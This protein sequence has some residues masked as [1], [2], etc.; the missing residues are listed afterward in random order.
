MHGEAPGPPTSHFITK[1]KLKPLRG[2]LSG[3]FGSDGIGG[4]EMRKRKKFGEAAVD[5]LCIAGERS[6]LNS[7][8]G[9]RSDGN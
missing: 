7:S 4:V 5:L 1:L 8:R 6:G 2:G 9:I 3:H